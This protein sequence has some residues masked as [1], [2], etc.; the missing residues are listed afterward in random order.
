MD[1]IINDIISL[2]GAT[3][4][5]GSETFSTTPTPYRDLDVTI[6]GDATPYVVFHGSTTTSP[7]SW[8]VSLDNSYHY[9]H[10]QV[11]GGTW[12]LLRAYPNFLTLTLGTQSVIRVI[13]SGDNAYIAADGHFIG[14]F[15]RLG[16]PGY[17]YCYGRISYTI[18]EFS[19][20]Q[21]AFMW[22][23]EESP[24]S[25]LARLL[26]GRHAKIV[27]LAD[28]GIKVSRFDT[29]D[30]LGTWST[31]IVK[32][33]GRQSPMPSIIEL[34]GAEHRAYSID[35]DIARLRLRFRRADNG[36]VVGEADTLEEAQHTI[37]IAREASFGYSAALYA[38]DPAVELEDEVTIGSTDYIVGSYGIAFTANPDTI[39]MGMNVGLRTK[40]PEPTSNT[41]GTGAW[42]QFKYG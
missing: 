12:T 30:D 17:G 2:S 11:N 3:Y 5:G 25:A 35:P 9:L 37:D 32:H 24:N 36:T 34:L 6:T 1:D 16:T 38:P 33:G 4:S 7:T 41:W 23:C 14:C 15:Q 28:G 40:F 20:M 26:R 10:H 29:R 21:D 31:S 39:V 27:G 19:N 22:G 13:V 18:S 42:G 8:R